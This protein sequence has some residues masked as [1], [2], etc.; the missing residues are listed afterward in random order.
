MEIYLASYKSTHSG[1]QGLINIGIRALDRALYSHSEICVGNPFESEVSCYSASG[2][3]GGVRCK[4]M[5]LSADRWDIVS[6]PWVSL[7]TVLACYE[8]AKDRKYDYFGVSRFALP[9]ATREHPDR[10]FCSEYAARVVGLADPWRFSPQCLHVTV[11]QLLNTYN[12]GET[13]GKV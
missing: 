9:F 4:R 3:D 12:L 8:E 5:Q 6:L 1:T 2:V 10:D 7:E 11:V 13:R